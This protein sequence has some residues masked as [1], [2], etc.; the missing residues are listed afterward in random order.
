MAMDKKF[1][2]KQ[3]GIS[4]GT[5]YN[6]EKD[7][8]FLYGLIR[9]YFEQKTTLESELLDHF[10]QLTEIDKD[11]TLSQIKTKALEA[12]KEKMLSKKE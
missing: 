1:V 8:P 5:L 10:S 12:K 2:S 9:E 3:I 6:W 11:I 4:L 7:K